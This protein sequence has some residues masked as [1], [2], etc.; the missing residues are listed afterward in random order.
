MT[1]KILLA[2]IAVLAVFGLASCETEPTLTEIVVSGIEDT[3]VDNGATFNVLDGVTALGNDGVDY[4]DQITLV[5]TSS[6]V[7]T[8]TGALDT[9]QAG[10][11]FVR[12][13]VRVGDI[14]AQ[15]SR[16]IT[17]KA[18][19]A[20]E[21]ELVVNGDMAAGIGGWNDPAVVYVADGAA[22][23]LS[24]EDGALKAEVTAGANFF[25][26]RF[27][28]MNIPFENGKTYEI[29]FE[30]KSSVEKEIALQVGELLPAAPWYNDFLPSAENIF[31]RT[32]TTEWA[33][34]SYKFTMT[35][36]NDKGG[37]LFGLGTVNGNAVNATMHFDNITIEESQ[38][39]PD[40][41]GPIFSGVEET[42]TLTTED[43]FN[44]RAGVT[45]VDVGA[46]DMT[47][48]IVVEVYNAN[49]ER[50]AEVDMTT[51]GT[52]R[53]VYIVSDPY[54]NFTRAETLLTIVE[55]AALLF[56]DS[57]ELVD[58]SFAS[59]P[60]V[61]PGEVQN[62]AY[63]DITDPGFW[64]MYDGSWSGA[65]AT[66]GVTDGKFEIDVTNVAGE[67][68]HFMLKQKGINL[69]E[70]ETYKL[71]FDA[72]ASVERPISVGFNPGLDA[73][74]FNLTTELQTYSV[75]F[76][77]EGANVE[78]RIEFLFGAAVGKVTLDN[79]KLEIGI[80]EDALV[81]INS[82]EFVDGSFA[83][84]PAVL[85]GEVQNDAYQ[86]ITDPGFW[87]MYDGSWSGAA[88]TY[89]VTDGKFE[90]DVT[91]VAGEVWH[92]MLKQKGIEL[93]KN[94]LYTLSFTAYASVDRPISVGFNPGLDA[95][96]VNLTTE[97]QTF[98]ISFY[99]TGD[100]VETRIEFLFGGAVG[101]VTLDDVMLYE[102]VYPGLLPFTDSGE[103]VDGAFATTAAE[104]PVEVQNDAYQDIT[105]P[106]FWYMYNGSWSGAA[107]TYGVTDGKF[108]IDVTN[109]AGEVWHF[110][111]KQKGINLEKDTMYMLT[112]TAFASVERSI[113]V[114]FNPGLEAVEVNLTTE[115]QTFE[116]PF[117]YTG[118]DVE[119]RIEFLFGGAV[120]KVTLDDVVLH[121][122]NTQP[123]PDLFISEYIEGSSNNKALE[124]YNPTGAALD[125]T[126]YVL[127][128]YNNGATPGSDGT[129]K[130]FDLTGITL[131][132]GETFTI[133]TDSF[134]GTGTY[135]EVQAYADSDSVVFFNGDDTIVLTK[136]GEVIDI[137]GVLGEDPWTLNGEVIAWTNKTYVRNA[138]ITSG[139]VVWDPTEWTVFDQDD[140]SHLGT[141][142]A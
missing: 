82:N 29:T 40:S 135:D 141:H 120:G 125:L 68:W 86:D 85:P 129:I 117:F 107:A 23:T 5:T 59:S 94:T 50:L 61:L 109:V 45:A 97:A 39:D 133:V 56:I 113:L 81:N 48:A 101:K 34:Y 72:F 33:T 121:V 20:V 139:S 128:Y 44:P 96:V 99:Y 42:L 115:A 37:I 69:I 3:S 77:Y 65:A 52:Y 132:A 17:V 88:A 15:Y 66:Y 14:V 80:D 18:P 71:S 64:Y 43:T 126:G 76:T 78:T 79:I 10:V 58:G 90:I 55:P 112:F 123:E 98:E 60:A 140:F 62:D 89:G 1:K 27:G 131:G 2:F 84:S 4:T 100:T 36:D 35:Q 12:Y 8:E 38:P 105:D 103:F 22:M 130:A 118:D 7:N 28:Q 116:I 102:R 114:G 108:E 6:A 75:E 134:A 51:P 119:T 26:P 63:Q 110:M 47:H 124:L 137:V 73:K 21:G 142:T 122:V 92:F 31:Y 70:G 111:L 11:H 104:L 25:T 13:E 9:L 57:E 46:G 24:A 53:I 49:N 87:Y 41:S 67:V 138:G 106:G 54:G 32:I 19:V 93:V 127:T 16:N 74:V 30:A 83:S 91:N 95:E 136:N